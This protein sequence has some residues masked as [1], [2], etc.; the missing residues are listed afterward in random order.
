MSLTNL[1]DPEPLLEHAL[2]PPLLLKGPR[3]VARLKTLRQQL[4]EPRLGPLPRTT[5]CFPGRS[6]SSRKGGAFDSGGRALPPGGGRQPMLGGHSTR[7]GSVVGP[8][9]LVGGRTGRLIAGTRCGGVRGG[10]T[11]GRGTRQW[12]VYGHTQRV[13]NH[14]RKEGCRTPFAHAHWTTGG[15]RGPES[16]GGEAC[17]LHGPM[18]DNQIMDGYLLTF[19]LL[20][21]DGSLSLQVFNRSLSEVRHVV[22]FLL[23]PVL[24][25][26]IL[27]RCTAL[28][29]LRRT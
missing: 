1:L 9:S 6:G 15:Q 16:W 11:G 23:E 18:H 7:S 21:P 29:T 4:L 10:R 27:A 19:L 3:V 28:G 14:R 26:L 13:S 2:Q 8:G 17:L 5:D 25:A 12:L 22:S 20:L 24:P